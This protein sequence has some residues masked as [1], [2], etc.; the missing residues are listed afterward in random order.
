[1]PDS[2]S[3]AQPWRFPCSHTAALLALSRCADV[4]LSPPRDEK[5]AQLFAMCDD[6][7]SGQLDLAEFE[8][9]FK[10]ILREAATLTLTLT[11]TLA[12]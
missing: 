7:N 6:D 4:G 10:V 8:A 11:L 1:M 5:V 9:F 12:T 2:T 3:T